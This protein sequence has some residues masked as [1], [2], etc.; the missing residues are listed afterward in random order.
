MEPSI[1]KTSDGLLFV[2][3]W[4]AK[5]GEGLNSLEN[6]EVRSIAAVW[7]LWS[8]SRVRGALENGEVMSIVRSRPEPSCWASSV[9][10]ARGC[11]ANVALARLLPRCLVLLLDARK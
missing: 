5:C 10:K 7:Q 4:F 6:G 1:N 2:C 3:G 9:L 8:I 11:G